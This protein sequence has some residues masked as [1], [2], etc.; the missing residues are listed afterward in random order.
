MTTKSILSIAALAAGLTLTSTLATHAAVT[1]TQ[2]GAT[3]QWDITFDPITFTTNAEAGNL[4]WI[5]FDDFFARNSTA[6]GAYVS[7]TVELAVGAATTASYTPAF[8]N[9][10]FNQTLGGIRADALLINIATSGLNPAA[11]TQIVM[12]TSGIR[13][14][15]TDV[16]AMAAGPSSVA[17]WTNAGTR[18]VRTDTVLVAIPEPSSTALV[19]CLGLTLLVRRRR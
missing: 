16:P 3:N 13:F 2:V 5:V 10:T 11:S 9:G 15:S 12:S 8:A 6:Q 1:I 19:G 4:A 7:G 14:S 17:I 18:P